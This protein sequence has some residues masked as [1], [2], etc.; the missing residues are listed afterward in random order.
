MRQARRA[1]SAGVNYIGNIGQ[2]SW[3]YPSWRGTDVD[4]VVE[5]V[6]AV[7]LMASK[8]ADGAVIHEYLDDGFGARNAS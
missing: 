5:T 2:F 6:T 1:L 4:Q 8:N 7:G 3:K